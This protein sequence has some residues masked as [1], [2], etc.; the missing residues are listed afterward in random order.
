MSESDE[1]KVE[2]PPEPGL[3]E[4]TIRLLLGLETGW[5]F[6]LRIAGAVL[7]GAFAFFWTK[8]TISFNAPVLASLMAESAPSVSGETLLRLLLQIPFNLVALALWGGVIHLL[9]SRREK[10]F[11]AG[12]PIHR[13]GAELRVR[14]P[15]SQ[16]LTSALISVFGTS[17]AALMF[18]A[19]TRPSSPPLALMYTVFALIFGRAAFVFIRLRR[20]ILSGA[21]DL[22]IGLDQRTIRLP[23]TLG[24]KEPI[25]HSLSEVQ[26]VTATELLQ[27]DGEGGRWYR[28]A[29]MLKIA[30]RPRAERL[31]L[32]KD[33]SCAMEF[34]RW[35]GEQI[36]KPVKLPKR[37]LADPYVT[38]SA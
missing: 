11:P 14:L 27:T 9:W 32:W 1:W 15:Q 36:E 19:L 17:F 16:P 10:P 33:V 24:R 7:L 4:R 2:R 34:A 20:R 30:G 35:L 3:S 31:F 38:I 18:F 5:R 13:G 23:A 26:R 12:E 29:V 25:E 6:L 37:L 8:V 28:Y 21:E 22:V